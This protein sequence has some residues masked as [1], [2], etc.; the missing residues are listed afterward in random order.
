M[1]HEGPKLCPPSKRRPIYEGYRFAQIMVGVMSGTLSPPWANVYSPLRCAACLRA[2]NCMQW[3][4]CRTCMCTCLVGNRH[5]G[6]HAQPLALPGEAGACL[7]AVR[8]VG[9]LELHCWGLTAMPKRG[10]IR[11]KIGEMCTARDPAARPS[12]AGIVRALEH[13]E[14]KLVANLSSRAHKVGPGTGK[15]VSLLH[16]EGRMHGVHL[17]GGIQRTTAK[18]AVP[19]IFS[20]CT[21]RPLLPAPA[22]T[23]CRANAAP[24]QQHGP[25]M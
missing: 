4:A 2:C 21:C 15:Q 1:V 17:C 16:S 22:A 6:G 11:R 7:A 24:G 12:F 5:G 23:A 9:V 20:W 10:S 25:Q 3:H 8:Q 18:Q 13:L 19:F 14:Q